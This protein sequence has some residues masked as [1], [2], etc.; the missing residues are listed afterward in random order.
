MA[1]SY[2]AR[3]RRGLV[4]PDRESAEVE[5]PPALHS[6]R[7]P[8]RA[9][10]RRRQAGNPAGAAGGEVGFSRKRTGHHRPQQAAALAWPHLRSH[11]SRAE[12]RAIRQAE[13]GR[14]AAARADD[15][16][17]APGGFRRPP[18]RVRGAEG[19]PARSRRRFRRRHHR[20]AARRRRLWQ[21][22]ARQGA[23]PRSRH[24]GRLFRRNPVG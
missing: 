2:C 1:G 14:G 22:D 23:R 24:P 4:D 5:R 3:G 9:R 10:K 11:D 19:S 21:D 18:K 8:R 17:G 15:S 20:G 6:R 7:H 16:P 13:A 12:E